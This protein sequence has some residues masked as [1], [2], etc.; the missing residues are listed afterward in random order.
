[1][2]IYITDLKKIGKK[3]AFMK[4][5][6]LCLTPK[7]KLRFDKITHIDRKLQ[8][9]VGRLMVYRFLGA[10]FKVEKSGKLTH[11]TKY[12]SLSHSH[13]LVILALSQNPVGI[14]AEYTIKKRNFKNICHFLNWKNCTNLK[15]FYKLFTQYEADYKLGSQHKKRLHTFLLW[16]KFIICVASYTKESMEVFE[17]FP[18]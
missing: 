9:L 1:M 16:K 8:F 5:Y 11:K 4:E 13:N 2:K 15:E 17:Y 10:S 14:D 18:V 12:L 6:A 3:N 7:D